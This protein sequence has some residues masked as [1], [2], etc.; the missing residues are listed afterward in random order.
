MKKE[1]MKNINKRINE[2]MTENN[3]YTSEHWKLN[4]QLLI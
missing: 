1:Q 4:T 2:K 3:K